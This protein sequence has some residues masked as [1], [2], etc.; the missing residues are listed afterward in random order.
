MKTWQNAI[1]GTQAGMQNYSKALAMSA[2]IK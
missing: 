2:T 1:R